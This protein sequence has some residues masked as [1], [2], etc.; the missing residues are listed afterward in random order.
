MKNSF[1]AVLFDVDGTLTEVDSTGG[2]EHSI[3][4]HLAAEAAGI[5]GITPAEAMKKI[6][7]VPGR[8]SQ[9]VSRLFP[10]FGI[11]AEKFAVRLKSDLEKHTSLPHDALGFVRRLHEKG[12]KLYTATTNSKYIAMVKLSAIGLDAGYFDGFFGG[13]TP[14][15]PLGKFDP[16]FFPA[17]MRSLGMSPKRVMMAGNE[18]EHDLYPALSAGLGCGV[19]VDRKSGVQFRRQGRGVFVNSFDMTE[20]II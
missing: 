12:I 6:E 13:D 19:I 4:F 18:P 9:C 3:D 10:V 11:N 17:I 7:A 8:E 15:C 20:E 2:M 5:L 16:N 1:D 14:G